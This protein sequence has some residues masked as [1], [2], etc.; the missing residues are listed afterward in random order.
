M[1][2][3]EMRQLLELQECELVLQECGIVHGDDHDQDLDELK[4]KIADLRKD[5][6]VTILSHFDRLRQRGVGIAQEIEGRC[7]SCHMS[8]PPGDLARYKKSEIEVKCPN[9]N[10]YLYLEC[11]GEIK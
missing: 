6:P 8:I 9:C 11:Y 2:K 5:V 10:V 1:P 4:N 3:E 7:K